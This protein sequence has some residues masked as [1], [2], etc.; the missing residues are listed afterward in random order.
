MSD[1][2]KGSVWGEMV[3]FAECPFCQAGTQ[4]GTDGDVDFDGTEVTCHECKRDF[5]IEGEP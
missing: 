5:L 1:D 4:V 3:Y 2:P